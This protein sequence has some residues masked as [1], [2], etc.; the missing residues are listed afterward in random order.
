MTLRQ[1]PMRKTTTLPEQP[2]QSPP[3]ATPPPARTLA[4][5]V[6]HTVRASLSVYIYTHTYMH[7]NLMYLGEELKGDKLC[8]CIGQLFQQYRR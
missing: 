5:S 7:I 1:P 3:S 8:D 2:P 6:R 4:A